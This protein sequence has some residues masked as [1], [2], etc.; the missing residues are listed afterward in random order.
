MTT[1]WVIRNGHGHDE[2]SAPEVEAFLAEM[3]ALFEKY[4]ICVSHSDMGCGLELHRY[5][6]GEYDSNLM[7]EEVLSMSDH[8]FAFDDLRAEREPTR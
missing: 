8:R 7:L 1:R 4:R 6:P 2:E 5:E 3:V